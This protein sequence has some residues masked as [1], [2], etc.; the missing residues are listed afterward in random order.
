MKDEILKLNGLCKSFNDSLNKKKCSEWTPFESQLYACC[1]E[2][3]CIILE[4]V[5][6]DD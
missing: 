4:K 5:L 6:K 2:I 3:R 1:V